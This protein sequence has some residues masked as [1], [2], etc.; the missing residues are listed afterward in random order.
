MI[1]KRKKALPVTTDSSTV[2]YTSPIKVWRSGKDAVFSPGLTVLLLVFS[3]PAAQTQVV[4][5]CVKQA[6][7]TT[8]REEVKD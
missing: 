4:L 3:R 8:E 2:L 6:L 1:L 5:V 7:S